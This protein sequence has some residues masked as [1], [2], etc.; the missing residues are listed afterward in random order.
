MRNAAVDRLSKLIAEPTVRKKQLAEG[1]PM[2]VDDRGFAEG[3]FSLFLLFLVVFCVIWSTQAMAW[4]DNLHI[5]TLDTF[6]ALVVGTWAAKQRRVSARLV[7]GVALVLAIALAL[8]Q[9]ISLFD[10]GSIKDFILSIQQWWLVTISGGH[11]QDDSLS[12]PFFVLG[13][14]CLAFFSAFALYRWHKPW[15]VVLLNMCILVF[16]LNF[17]ANV[18]IFLLVL[19]LIAGLL[20]VLRFYLYETMQRWDLL[21]L[22]YDEDM[23]WS[24]MKTGLLIVTV[25]L[26]VA[27]VLPGSYLDPALGS[28]WTLQGSPLAL[29]QSA[30]GGVNGAGAGSDAALASNHGTFNDTWS[31][32]GNPNLTKDVVLRVTYSDNTQ[33]QYLALVNYDTYDNGWSIEHADDAQKYTLKA[34]E[35]LSPEATA[36]HNVQQRIQVVSSPQEQRP[37][38]IGATQIIALSL[39]AY[40]VEGVG[41][42]VAWLGNN[43]SMNVGLHYTVTSA[44]SSASITELRSI[45]MPD[46]A[47]RQLPGGHGPQQ[48]RPI[49]YF[50]SAIV[51]YFTQISPQLKKDGRIQSLA[52]K[53]VADAHAQTMYDKTVA[54]ETYL[55]DHYTYSTDIHPVKGIDPVLWFLF[56]NP[57]KNG[58]CNYFSTAFTLLARSIG[59][60]AREVVGYASGAREQNEYVI[61]GTD[62]HSWSQVYFAG[63]GWINFEPS[64]SFKTFARP[65]AQQFPASTAPDNGTS[66]LTSASQAQGEQQR[67][68]AQGA[69]G[70]GA[71]AAHLQQQ[72]GAGIGMLLVLCLFALSCGS[73]A[74]FLWWRRLYRR[75]SFVSQ[76]YGR[77]CMLAEWAGLERLASQTPYEYLHQV[78]AAVLRSPDEV[79]ALEHLGDMYVQERWAAP[80][81]HESVAYR[82][83]PI[84]PLDAWRLLRPRLFFYVVRHPFFLWYVVS[85]IV[86]QGKTVLQRLLPR[87]T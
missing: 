68:R 38:L 29:I 70:V 36:T 53:I 78:S 27:L 16:N 39:P 14:L 10:G 33:P 51:T 75:Y 34:N 22:R 63:Y 19:F 13:C 79:V 61:R 71:V 44:I 74:F 35:A 58:Y 54:L 4:I 3:F 64:A 7:Y 48:E 30:L 50:S 57:Q 12:L 67:L 23:G 76:L 46:Q 31:L 15:L 59:I 60:P 28:L 84:A 40:L 62:A 85:A 32:G 81:S 9:T 73:L 47:P 77:I 49:G 8:W 80:G 83:E 66:G 37:Y 56:E 55:R 1:S 52:Q 2:P 72:L 69:G 87:H 65:V 42:N 11:S 86:L 45:L 82:R 26:V 17:L 6:V 20:L 21:N 24:V 18:Y 25:I 41:G 5:L 43:V